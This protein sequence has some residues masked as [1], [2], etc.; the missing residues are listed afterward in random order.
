MNVEKR[1]KRKAKVVAR[2]TLL[3]DTGLVLD[4]G[5]AAELKGCDVLLQMAK[6]RAL[7]EDCWI[8]RRNTKTWTA[9]IG[10]ID[11]GKWGDANSVV[12]KREY[13]VGVIHRYR[14]RHMDSTTQIEPP[15]VP[16]VNSEAMDVSE[17]MYES[18][19]DE[20]MSDP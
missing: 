1:F 17:D 10:E 6:H 2:A 7:G 3:A 15:M 20:E 11:P 4:E 14:D 5:V 18:D 9:P 8:L 19:S 12:K 13:L 16:D